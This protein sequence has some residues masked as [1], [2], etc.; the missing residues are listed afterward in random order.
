[1]DVDACRSCVHCN[2][3]RMLPLSQSGCN[4]WRSR[5]AQRQWL[6]ASIW[7]PSSWN[8][9][10]KGGWLYPTKYVILTY[11]NL[12]H[13]NP[14]PISH[15]HTPTTF[16][17]IP[18]QSACHRP[19][20]L[21]NASLAQRRSRHPRHSPNRIWGMLCPRANGVLWWLGLGWPDSARHCSPKRQP[22]IVLISLRAE[23]DQQKKTCKSAWLND[24]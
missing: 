7:M 17:S 8:H 19:S 5:D 15:L 16:H 23:H 13:T 9:H 2:H 14:I 24:I 11:F 21:T 3:L 18:E 4:L 12:T 20:T 22:H 10:P 1:M 6:Q